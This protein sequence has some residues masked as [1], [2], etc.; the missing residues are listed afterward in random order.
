MASFTKEELKERYRNFDS[1]KLIKIVLSPQDYTPEAVAAANE[2]IE[3]RGHSKDLYFAKEEQKD[4]KSIRDEI[5]REIRQLAPQIKQMFKAGLSDEEI[6]AQIP[7]GAMGQERTTEIVKDLLRRLYQKK[8]N[9]KITNRTIGGCVIGG[10]IGFSLGTAVVFYM[11]GP[12]GSRETLYEILY[13]ALFL[14]NFSAI[15]LI[16]KQ[17]MRNR[18]ILIVSLTL[19]AFSFV[20]GFVLREILYH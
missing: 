11:G 1:A 13:A 7:A 12:N 18:L 3:E 10:L 5:N 4:V 6:H 9:Q 2:L 20:S 8:E 14:V 15:Y 17:S 19:P 16:T